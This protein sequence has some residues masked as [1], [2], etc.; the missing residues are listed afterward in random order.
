MRRMRA[1]PG[2]LVVGAIALMLLL[3]VACEPPLP[4]AEVQGL[5]THTPTQLADASTSTTPP[6]TPTLSEP[7]GKDRKDKETAVPT[8]SSE[9]VANVEP[10]AEKVVA[11]AKADL[12]QRLGVTE[13]AIV[14]KSVEAVQ[15]RNS[16][17]GCPQPGMMYAQVLTPGF[18]IV[19]EAEGQEYEYHTDSDRLVVLCADQPQAPLDPPAGSRLP[20]FVEMVQSSLLPAS[21]AQMPPAD[22]GPTGV[23]AFDPSN[24]LLLVQPSVQILST[25]E[26]LV[27][28]TTA[29][30][31]NRP[32]VH[33]ELFQ[34]PSS[35]ATPLSVIAIDAD[36]GTLT[37]AYADQTF[38][39]RP[40]QSRTFKQK[41]AGELAAIE[42]TTIINHGRPTAIG[43]LP[44]DPGS[45]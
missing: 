28:L 10:E 7:E 2:F 38:E 37:L 20:I 44:V 43:V 5:P 23:F 18:E 22:A 21:P 29:Q 15:W 16:S 25:T 45:R 39:L 33:S 17:L 36:S 41:G 35:Q 14:V 32:Y 31:P 1:T 9:N 34:I 26:V 24:R 27:G 12:M 4:T 6:A 3:S 19:L 13:E 40:G 8:L 30:M 42:I 11:T